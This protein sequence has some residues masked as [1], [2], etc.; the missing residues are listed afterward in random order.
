LF[1]A[2]S[3]GRHVLGMQIAVEGSKGMAGGN[4]QPAGATGS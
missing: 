2:V 1:V 4:R 3:N